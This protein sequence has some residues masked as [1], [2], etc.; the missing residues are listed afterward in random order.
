LADSEPVES[1]LRPLLERLGIGLVV[2]DDEHR[3]QLWNAFMVRYSGIPAADVVGRGLFEAFPLLPRDWLELK[4]RTVRM[5]RNHSFTSWR[6][7]PYLFEFPHN[8]PITGSINSMRQDCTFQPLVHAGRVYTC[9][10]IQDA[11][12]AAIV[13][14]Q[15]DEASDLNRTLQQAATTDALT[16]VMNRGQIERRLAGEFHRA[17]RYGV[18]FSVLMFDIDHFKRVNDT[19]GHLGGDEVLRCIARVVQEQIRTED[20]LGRYGGEEFLVVLPH[21][22]V[23]SAATLAERLRVCV[24]TLAVAHGD[25]TIS[26]TMSLGTAQYLPEMKD[27]L[28]LIHAADIALYQSKHRGRNCVTQF[29]A[30]RSEQPADPASEAEKGSLG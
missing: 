29:A 7:R 10:S 30:S 12:D 25:Q 3:I 27:Y 4:F 6:Q 21:T 9:I 11:T 24:E 23:R 5:L 26:V 1:L 20:L 18:A 15:L 28:E 19:Y 14:Q 16:S 8:R 2:V 17:C 13:Q 22:D